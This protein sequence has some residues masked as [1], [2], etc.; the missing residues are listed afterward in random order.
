[1][2]RKKRRALPKPSREAM[3][4]LR[5]DDPIGVRTYTAIQKSLRRVKKPPK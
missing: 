2:P 3:D 4:R 5:A 1:M